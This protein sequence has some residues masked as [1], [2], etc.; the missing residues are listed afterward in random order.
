MATC[1][2][3]KG[4]F[5]WKRIGKKWHAVDADSSSHWAHCRPVRKLEIRSAGVMVGERY[6][7]SCGKCDIPPWDFGACTS[8]LPSTCGAHAMQLQGVR[9]ALE[10]H[11]TSGADKSLA[12]VGPQSDSCLADVRL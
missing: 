8:L 10:A 11:S 3:C 9:D 5:T 2:S 7:P 1:K 6:L 4:R 12:V